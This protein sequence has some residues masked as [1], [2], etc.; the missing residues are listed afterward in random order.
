MIAHHSGRLV[1][2]KITSST[3]QP[4]SREPSVQPR[5]Q[6]LVQEKTSSEKHSCSHF[7][8]HSTMFSKTRSTHKKPKTFLLSKNTQ[9]VYLR[10]SS[11][12]SCPAELST[13][14]YSHSQFH[15]GKLPNLNTH[16]HIRKSLMTLVS[17]Y[18]IP[19]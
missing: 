8:F 3:V 11:Y 16:L 19:N 14:S 2:K 10:S 6:K 5:R 17:D 4:R 7:P 15:K 18:P 9:L 1:T 13:T 12:C